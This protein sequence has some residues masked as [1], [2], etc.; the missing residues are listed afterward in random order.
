MP[1]ESLS[2]EAR[3]EQPTEQSAAKSTKKAGKKAARKT[4]QGMDSEA[5]DTSSQP[6][7]NVRGSKKTTAKKAP[8]STDKEAAQDKGDT[9]E[10]KSTSKQS[11]RGRG[12][13]RQSQP[14]EDEPKVDLDGKTVAK[15][16]WKIFLGEVNEE[17]LALIADKDARELARRSIRIAEI[18]SREEAI[19]A[20]KNKGKKSK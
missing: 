12:R 7:R 9:G 8:K 2:P 5:G 15:R 6:K 13:G 19:E 3:D 10:G 1:E 16:A 11:R 18:Y 14:K 20:K 4:A 17:G